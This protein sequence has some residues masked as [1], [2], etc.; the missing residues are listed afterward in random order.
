MRWKTRTRPHKLYTLF[1]D[2]WKS[3]AASQKGHCWMINFKIKTTHNRIYV[4]AHIWI[5]KCEVKFMH[6]VEVSLYGQLE[7]TGSFILT[8]VCNRCDPETTKPHQTKANAISIMLLWPPIMSRTHSL[9]YIQLK[10]EWCSINP[11]I[12]MSFLQE[13]TWIYSPNNVRPVTCVCK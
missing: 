8:C 4:Y 3:R 9:H 13:H 11:S 12:D 2:N 1:L 6:S 7:E 10:V 5:V